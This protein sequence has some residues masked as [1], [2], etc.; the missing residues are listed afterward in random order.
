M[1]RFKLRLL[2]IPCVAVVGMAVL[3]V[4][5]G[6]SAPALEGTVLPG[7]RAPDFR[8]SDQ[9]GHPTSL[10]TF[11]GEPVLITF[12][13][14]H[15]SEQCPL[16]VDKIRD[17]VSDVER[18]DG[19]VAVL[20]VSADPEGDT[21]QAVRQF[22]KAHRILHRWH[23]LTGSRRELTKIWRAYYVYAAPKSAPPA[24][25]DSHTSATYLIDQDGRERVL[26]AGNPD[27]RTLTRDLRILAGL[28]PEIAGKPL[29]APQPGYP[30]PDLSGK[31]VNGT[32]LRLRNL[33]GKVVLLNFW[34]TSCPPC[35][36]E[37]PL[38]DQWYRRFHRQGLV[39][40][41]VDKQEDQG[42]VRRFVRSLGVSYP[43]VL[44]RSGDTAS[45][46]D[47]YALP[48]SFLIDRRG[49]VRSVRYGVVDRLFLQGQVRPLL[50]PSMPGRGTFNK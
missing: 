50:T 28:P 40:V 17:A 23:Y 16:V 35:R 5:R 34:S 13:E 19:K 9:A 43:L 48:A 37:M 36:S 47:L 41:G 30:A 20:A 15:C 45:R 11:R 49:I 39:V 38:L 31:S 12:V 33:R 27:L 1:K 26:F 24:V 3:L 10:K 7:N 22:S 32:T 8:L 4:P 46:Y 42:A 18:G 6:S 14:A 29:A 25:R 21:P 44:D 2:F